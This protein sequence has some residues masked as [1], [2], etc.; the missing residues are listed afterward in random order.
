MSG[1]SSVTIETLLR[2]A[3]DPVTF[4]DVRD[5][6]GGCGSSF[7]VT[8]VSEKFKGVPLLQQHR[9]VH[10]AVESEMK[11][12]HAFSQK[13]YTPERWAQLNANKS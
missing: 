13:T 4:I 3:L 2:E 12:I 9:L 8:V 11:D 7:E 6:S 10:Q 1:V 5:T